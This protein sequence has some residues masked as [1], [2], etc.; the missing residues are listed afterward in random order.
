M[1]AAPIRVMLYSHDAQGL[2]HLRRNLALAHH[3]S[4]H[5]PELAQAPVTGLLVAGLT[6]GEGFEVPDGFDWLVLPG[7]VK[8][9]NGYQPRRLNS[10]RA[11]LRHLRSQVIEAALIS[12]APDLF[13]IDRHPY[14]VRQELLEPLR[15][16]R[17]R[18]P[19][20]R[21]V[22]GLREVL[23]DPGTMEREWASL[24]PGQQLRELVDQVWVYGDPTVHDLASTGEGPMVLADRM[25]FTGYLSL[26]RYAADFSGTSSVQVPGP[27]VLTTVGGGSDA[28]P[29]LLHSA[30]ME[31]PVGHQHIVVCGPQL[32]EPDVARV[33]RV[34]GPRTRV[35]RTWPG[36]SRHV[37]EAAAVISMGGYNT[38]C[39]ILSTSV[40]SLIVP[41]E[42]PRLEQLIRARSL[43]HCGAVEV[44]RSSEMTPAALGQWAAS[45]VGRTVNRER[46]DLAGLSTVPL[47][48]HELL[49]EDIEEGRA[50]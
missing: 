43:E 42:T 1:S 34:A 41:R 30:A 48:A 45:A 2:G 19:G 26:G 11:Q 10:T 33:A 49:A 20:A 28:L 36:L 21:V 9:P 3:L 8:S 29:L 23:D 40:P 39:E 6:P 50:A 27:F 17:H 16:L 14:G 37:N 46:I 25:R 47:L 22:L 7:I 32:S 4:Q 35:L 24:G 38:V 44:L 18:H 15:A 13:I 31:P 12:F 5:L